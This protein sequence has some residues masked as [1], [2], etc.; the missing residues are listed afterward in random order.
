MAE[1]AEAAETLNAKHI[2]S[3]AT[4]ASINLMGREIVLIMNIFPAVVP[5]GLPRQSWYR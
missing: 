5:R 1:V 3:P 2:A 4:A